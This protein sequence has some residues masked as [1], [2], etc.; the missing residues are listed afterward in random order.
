MPLAGEGGG[1]E[2][3]HLKLTDRKDKEKTIEK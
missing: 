2:G 1:G 3:N